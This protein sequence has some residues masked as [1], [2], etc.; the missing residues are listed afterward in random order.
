[1]SSDLV[2]LIAEGGAYW[3]SSYWVKGVNK[4]LFYA[5]AYCAKLPNVNPEASIWKE[6]VR[7]CESIL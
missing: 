7:N 4:S 5:K 6:E 1:M 3:P 2:R